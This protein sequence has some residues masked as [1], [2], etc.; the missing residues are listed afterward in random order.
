MGLKR[1]EGQGSEHL[2]GLRAVR[3]IGGLGCW[4]QRR[5]RAGR[6]KGRKD[7]DLKVAE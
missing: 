3:S 2:E 6:S 4:T 1:L 5:D 7:E